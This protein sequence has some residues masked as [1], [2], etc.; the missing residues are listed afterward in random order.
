M[1]KLVM[2]NNINSELSI[3][4]ADNKPA[5]SIIGSDIT[6]A[7]DTINDFPLDA[8]DGDTVIVRDL[9]R[10]GTFIYDSSKVAGHN[11]GTNFN[12]WIRQYDGPVNVKW[13]GAVG[14]GVTDA[15]SS[16]ISCISYC[17]SN[18]KIMYSDSSTFYITSG[19]MLPD[20]TQE[21][22][23]F[24]W[25]CDNTRIL[26]SNS[27]PVL[28][29]LYTPSST[30]FKR[31]I[32]IY[33]DLFLEFES[34]LQNSI[35]YNLGNQYNCSYGNIYVKNA[36]TAFYSKSMFATQWGTFKSILCQ[37]GFV[38]DPL[39][40]GSAG[41]A[42]TSLKGN[43]YCDSTSY[44]VVIENLFYSELSGYVQ[45][46]SLSTSNLISGDIPVALHAK[47]NCQSTKLKFGL[48]DVQGVLLLVNPS[49]NLLD[50]SLNTQLGLSNDWDT[51]VVYNNVANNALVS[52]ESGNTVTLNQVEI[53]TNSYSS[54]S[55]MNVVYIEDD[56]KVTHKGGFL[57]KDPSQSSVV[58]VSGNTANYIPIGVRY[59]DFSDAGA[60]NLKPSTLPME[61][62][63][64]QRIPVLSDDI[65]SGGGS[66]VVPF[67]TPLT[68]EPISV[69]TQW[70][71]PVGSQ[72][73]YTNISIVDTTK[74]ETKVSSDAPNGY[75]L[76]IIVIGKVN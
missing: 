66:L 71:T 32:H 25:E 59:N 41:S 16:F 40:S 26:S 54:S 63:V 17:F 18:G 34:Y 9:N 19:I 69:M 37:R 30:S 36:G 5:K 49:N 21:N 38:T 33:G 20:S 60:Y 23:S 75:W 8:S 12:G 29:I 7:V 46:V 72:E 28:T 3:T 2:K 4:H 15:L 14:D 64:I 74:S 22:T 35:G 27:N 68:V 56:A 13:F 53:A 24:T 76:H 61:G 45:G 52:V 10:G 67:N 55:N 44:G 6:V 57:C 58:K 50:C 73:T 48:E 39:A 11:D 42:S 70:V 43:I 51:S 1:S 65:V 31:N 47:Q 62:L